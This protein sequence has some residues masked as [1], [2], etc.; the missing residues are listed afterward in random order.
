MALRYSTVQAARDASGVPISL[1]DDAT[2]TRVME[3]VE[4]LLEA[5]YGTVFTPTI[6]IAILDGTGHERVLLTNNPVLQIRKCTTNDQVVQPQHL[7]ISEG[8]GY[9]YLNEGASVSRFAAR[10]RKVYVEY[11]Y[12]WLE[13]ARNRTTAP[14]MVVQSKLSSAYTL[15]S[16]GGDEGATLAVVDGSLFA[17]NDWVRVWGI[18]G[19]RET[20]RVTAVDGNDLTVEYI[21]QPHVEGSYVTKLQ[22]PEWFQELV[23]IVT[24]IALCANA[25]G[26]TFDFIAGYTIGDLQVQKGV[27]YTHWREALMRL[28]ARRDEIMRT[29]TPRSHVL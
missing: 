23:A 13:E 7:D 29:R 2:V 22:C 11:V 3:E 16:A 4:F 19:K 6:D 8:S 17:A 27:P 14:Y 28:V 1:A 20:V 15:S 10:R 9:I 21:S 24:G 25:V 18:D 26:A 5:H 12:A